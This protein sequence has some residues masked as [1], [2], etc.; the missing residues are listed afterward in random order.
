MF[1]GEVRESVMAFALAM[2]DKLRRLD[3]KKGPWEDLRGDYL[4]SRAFQEAGELVK[5]MIDFVTA[6]ILDDENLSQYEEAVMGEC[7][8]VANFVMM[9]FSQNHPKLKN[10]KR[11]KSSDTEGVSSKP[12][13]VMK[14]RV[15]YI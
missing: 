1:S 10:L 9:I 2:E 8:D 12:H 14:E 7:V 13:D 15:M 11:G 4:L 3:D 6:K 5:A